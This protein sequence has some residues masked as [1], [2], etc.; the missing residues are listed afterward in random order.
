MEK[1][2]TYRKHQIPSE[3]AWQIVSYQRIQW[4]F[5]HGKSN[6][7]WDYMPREMPA[8]SFIL[9]DEQML[10]S[11][12][13]VN[14]RMIEFAGE[15]LNCYGLSSVFTY[16]AFR[17]GGY[18]S[19]V[20]KAATDQILQSDADL[21]MLFCGQPLRAFYSACQW[22][23]ADNARIF[24]G[25]KNNPT[26]KSDNLVMMLFVSDKARRLRPRITTE[27]VFVGPITW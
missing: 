7:G 27:P 12:A 11:H 16:P 22:E 1:L 17:K 13:S 6:Q 23:P 14:Q 9:A 25:D 15:Q 26:F 3:F 24:Y 5:L 2:H 20:V 18:A 21:A 8:I 19:R 10:I 4:P